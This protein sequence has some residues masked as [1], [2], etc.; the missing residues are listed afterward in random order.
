M[1]LDEGAFP[2]IRKFSIEA[3]KGNDWVEVASGTTIGSSKS[4]LFEALEAKDFR[5]QITEAIET[6][7]IAEFELLTYN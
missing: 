1:L 7:V 2:R 4:L 3:L 6:P 5:L